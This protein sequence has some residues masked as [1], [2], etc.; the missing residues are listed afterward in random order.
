[1]TRTAKYYLRHL[2]FVL[3]CAAIALLIVALARPQTSESNETS[4]AEGIDIMMALD[5]SSSMLARDFRPDRITAAKEITQNFINDRPNDRI[6][7]VV[8]AGEA[9]T[10]SPLTTDKATLIT[11]LS[12]VREGMIDDGTAIGNGLATAVNRLRESSAASKVIILLTDGVNNSGQVAP[13]T[14]AEIAQTFG[15]RVY[16][17]GIGTTG[18]APT[19]AIDGYGRITYVQAPV[20]IDEEIL[21]QI[22]EMTGGQ[23][24]RA[25]DNDKLRTIYEEINQLE[26]T[27]IEVDSQ[28]RWF[29]R[30]MSFA[31]AALALV[32]LEL[33]LRYF[34]FRRI[35]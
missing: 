15:I 9:F 19:P 32:V 26:K 34:Y 35:P 12:R 18:M 16:T 17:I 23:Y 33:L 31:L 8:F 3:R 22:S 29:E 5:I 20:E 25:T 11:L 30:F 21:T 1:L 24:F 2:P 4:T 6:G 28:T 27:Q 10:Q 14:A 7:L 13:L